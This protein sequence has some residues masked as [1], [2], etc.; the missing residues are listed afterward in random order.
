M[1]S[2]GKIYH[3]IYPQDG[4]IPTGV[5]DVFLSGIYSHTATKEGGNANMLS[6]NVKTKYM[7]Q[8]QKQTELLGKGRNTYKYGWEYFKTPDTQRHKMG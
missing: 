3:L 4:R 5:Y 2:Q 6:D 1:F 8:S 7:R